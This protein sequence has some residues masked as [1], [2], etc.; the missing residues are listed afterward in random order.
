MTSSNMEQQL[1]DFRNE[2]LSLRM[3]HPAIIQ[4]SHIEIAAALR[5]AKAITALNLFVPHKD[6]PKIQA[7]QTT[8]H[9]L[10]RNKTLE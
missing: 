3:C 6:N 10:G 1:Q 5:L 2:M 9:H 7:S 4:K 8:K